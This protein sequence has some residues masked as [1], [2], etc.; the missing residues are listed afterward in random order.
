MNKTLKKIFKIIISIIILIAIVIGIIFHSPYTKLKDLWVTT[1][2]KTMSHQYLAK[3][4]VSDEEIEKIMNRNKV[5]ETMEEV[6]LD[7]IIIED[8]QKDDT[9]N[10]AVNNQPI[11]DN[12]I[13]KIDIQGDG[14]QGKLL[15]IHD[16]SKVFVGVSNKLGEYGEKLLDMGKNYNAIGG[17]NAGGFTDVNG[18][19]SG[20]DGQGLTISEGKLLTQPNHEKVNLIG[21]NKDNKLVIGNYS[22]NEIKNMNI[23]DAVQFNPALI[24]NGQPTEIIGDGG[25]GIQPRT[26]IGQRK[27]GVVLLLVIDGRQLS[28]IGITIKK[29]QEIMI[30]YKAE[31]ATNLD[32]G[33]STTM[34]YNGDIINKPCSSAGPRY[35]PNGFFIKNN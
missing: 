23:R 10:K 16:P 15:I 17:I 5:I 27:D 32:G 24:I 21:F 9:A 13:E 4:F 33:S 35:L 31:N 20:G 29:L 25:W 34:I 28:S 19:G 18:V 7:N 30:D 6:N 26:C 1:A 3:L 11:V 12:T 8:I 22:L 14:Y 2:M